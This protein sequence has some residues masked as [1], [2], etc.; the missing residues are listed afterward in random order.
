MIVELIEECFKLR[1]LFRGHLDPDQDTA[2][3]RTVVAIMEQAYI[4]VVAH[5]VQKI[6][7]RPRPIGKL[8]T[9]KK[10][11][12]YLVSASA[13]QVAYVQFGHLVIAQIY[14]AQAALLQVFDQ[15]GG[16]LAIT[17]RY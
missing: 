16:F 5:A 11:I 14:S 3:V 15:I 1:L 17:N 12:L 4:P 8:K 13:Y 6:H 2:V 7:E 10:L 9:I